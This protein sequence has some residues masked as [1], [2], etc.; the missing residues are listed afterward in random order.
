MINP[1]RQRIGRQFT[2]AGSLLLFLLIAAIFFRLR[3]YADEQE[4]RLTR[5]I[6]EV[7]IRNLEGDSRLFSL[8]I[9]RI[10]EKLRLSSMHI[11]KDP[12]IFQCVDQGDPARMASFL[13][14]YREEMDFAVLTDP[15]GTVIGSYC[16]DAGNPDLTALTDILSR[17]PPLGRALDS[18]RLD[19]RNNNGLP[20]TIT[21]HDAGFFQA[22]GMPPETVFPP[23]GDGPAYALSLA[24]VQTVMDEF[25]DPAARVILFRL[26]ASTDPQPDWFFKAA[27]LS[28]A[29]FSGD[30]VIAAAGFP[31]NLPLT[32]PPAG[33]DG[34]HAIAP[35]MSA[36]CRP[37]TDVTG[38]KVGAICVA[39]SDQEIC[40]LENETRAEAR[41]FRRDLI[42]LLGIIAVAGLVLLLFISQR[43]SVSI[44]G[45]LTDIVAHLSRITESLFASASE[46]ARAGAESAHGAAIQ[47]AAS[48]KSM[49]MIL[50]MTD[51]SRSTAI[52]TAGTTE[53]MS[54]NIRKSVH[55]VKLM[56]ELTREISQIETDSDEM[57]GI[58]NTIDEIAFQTNLLSINAGVEA[59]RAGETGRG[60]AVVAEEVRRLA[61]RAADAASD[62]RQLLESTVTRIRSSAVTL[63]RM[64]A[65]FDDI[66]SSATTVGEKST[67]ITNASEDVTESLEKVLEYYQDTDRIIQQNAAASQE[68]AGSAGDLRHQIG[69]LTSVTGQ[70]REMTGA[71]PLPA[72]SG[73]AAKTDPEEAGP[74][75]AAHQDQAS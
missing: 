20:G 15:A 49:E 37:L 14:F 31:E 39:V 41:R 19:E 36:H 57:I 16:P 42:Q 73:K 72:G 5:H 56:V 24:A 4:V 7:Q 21:R 34:P 48:E 30:R 11:A 28:C 60:F 29:V 65:D 61:G 6:R 17:W 12:R 71:A 66:L 40:A 63:D 35:G 74:H 64:N 38:A 44:T 47:A 25:G 18:R 2:L 52:L 55:T 3:T 59:V 45:P 22:M 1:I 62:T 46:I 58:I 75:P 13:S 8:A 53:L 33:Q 26:L 50:D 67:T 70:L 10:S 51:M 54:E 69:R 23:G 27:G 68:L 43:V 32:A 9:T